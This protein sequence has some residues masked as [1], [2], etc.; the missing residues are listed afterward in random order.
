MSS[1]ESR[2]EGEGLAPRQSGKP[3][4][5]ARV[6]TIST[7]ADPQRTLLDRIDTARKSLVYRW[8]ATQ[9]RG[10]KDDIHGD[11][12]A[13][14]ALYDYVERGNRFSS[15]S[16]PEDGAEVERGRR[17]L[18]CFEQPQ[19]ARPVVLRGGRGGVA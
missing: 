15:R 6:K 5:E 7:V 19:V 18:A 1:N 3:H 4:T 10:P 2:R 14:L 9:E 11:V 17:V 16:R 13:L 12:C 8:H